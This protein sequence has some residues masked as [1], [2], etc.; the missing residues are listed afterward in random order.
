[1]TVKVD[2]SKF[3]KQMERVLDDV[4]SPASMREIGT[5]AAERI[6]KRTRLGKGVEVD[7]GDASPLKAL[8]DQYK[9]SRKN[10]RGSKG[11]GKLS[12]FT[13]PGKSNLTFTGQLLDS[14]RVIS[15][16][17]A[18]VVIGLYGGRRGGGTNKEIGG[19]VSEDRPF[20]HL[21]KAE[22]E[23]MKRTIRQRIDAALKRFLT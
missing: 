10:S 13:T 5:D 21:S 12:Q 4:A 22:L 17:A 6:R 18:S 8:S 1:M 9:K 16:G 11:L 20:L 15:Q 14:I 23:G 19:Y 7:G 2:L 3:K